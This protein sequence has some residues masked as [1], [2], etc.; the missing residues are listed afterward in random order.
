M[1]VMSRFQKVLLVL[2]AFIIGFSQMAYVA[3]IGLW[4]YF[5]RSAFFAWAIDLFYRLLYSSRLVPG[6][7]IAR[8]QGKYLMRRL[9]N[10]FSNTRLPPDE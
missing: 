7:L 9:K 6:S 8:I 1:T 3:A 10:G 2:I 5:Y 4:T